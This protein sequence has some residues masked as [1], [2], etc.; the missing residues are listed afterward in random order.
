MLNK[1]LNSIIVRILVGKCA[2]WTFGQ[3]ASITKNAVGRILRN[4]I[5]DARII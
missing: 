1:T 4:D 5:R 3:T 2:W